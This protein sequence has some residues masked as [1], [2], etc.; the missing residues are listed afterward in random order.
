[1]DRDEKRGGDLF[2]ANAFLAHSLDVGS[3]EFSRM[4]A[5]RLFFL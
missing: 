5:L 2:L 3:Y 4:V 1:M